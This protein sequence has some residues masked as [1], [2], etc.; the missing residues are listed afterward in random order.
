[1]IVT[2]LGGP[3]RRRLQRYL[4]VVLIALMVQILAPIAA[5]WAAAV[6]ISDPL[7]AIEICHSDPSQTD[8]G[9]QGPEHGTHAGSC[10]ICCVAQTDASFE[11]P[12]LVALGV[13]YGP[14]AH[15]I[16]REETLQLRAFPVDSNAWARAPPAMS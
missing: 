15:V 6:A 11:P 14:P 13:P 9:R 16:W 7:G 1:M 4:P 2:G 10:W 3:V 8:R 12:R 5:C